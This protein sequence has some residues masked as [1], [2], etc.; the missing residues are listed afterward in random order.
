MKKIIGFED[1]LISESGDIFNKHGKKM[2]PEIVGQHR[3][4]L[5]HRICLTKDGKKYKPLVH[6][7]MAFTYLGPPT[8]IEGRA[9]VNHKDVN[10]LNN[11]K[12]NLEWVSQS[13]NMEHS[14]CKR[15]EWVSPEGEIFTFKNLNQFAITNGLS[16]GNLSEV[17]R[18]KRSQHKGWKFNG[19]VGSE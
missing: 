1:Y 7:L 4:T 6:R 14:R 18:G 17:T 3:G 5:Y 9:Q 8:D 16:V 19:F 12:D 10:G 2:K 13:Q 11:H 15:M